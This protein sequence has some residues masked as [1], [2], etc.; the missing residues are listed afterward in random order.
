MLDTRYKEL[1]SYEEELRFLNSFVFLLKT[2]FGSS[3]EIT[4]APASEPFDV[5]PLAIQML[6]EVVVDG[7]VIS[8]EHPLKISVTPD[9]HHIL[10]AAGVKWMGRREIDE[11]SSVVHNITERYRFLSSQAVEF[12]VSETQLICKLPQLHQFESHETSAQFHE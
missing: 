10:I 1:I 9:E 5:S 6:L 2:R 11:A 8:H 7:A 4:L 3:I 12:E